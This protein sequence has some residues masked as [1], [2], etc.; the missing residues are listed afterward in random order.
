MSQSLALRYKEICDQITQLE[1]E[2]E[3]IRVQLFEYMQNS[4]IDQIKTEFGTFSKGQ[5]FVWHYTDDFK[6][7]VKERKEEIK[8]QEKEEQKTMT[9]LV[10]EF[11]TIR[12]K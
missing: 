11:L 10:E 4:K 1:A 3:I 5:R 6:D 8:L 12:L 7:W 9:P 2:K